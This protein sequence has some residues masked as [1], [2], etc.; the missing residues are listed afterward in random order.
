MKCSDA[1]FPVTSGRDENFNFIPFTTSK[2]PLAWGCHI[3]FAGLDFTFSVQ[4]AVFYICLFILYV[5]GMGLC[6]CTE[7]CLLRASVPNCSIH[8][9]LFLL[10]D[11]VL[12]AACK[13]GSPTSTEQETVQEAIQPVGEGGSLHLLFCT[14]GAVVCLLPQAWPV[15][16]RKARTKHSSSEMRGAAGWEVGIK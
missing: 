11:S 7:G 5:P 6:V 8:G 14:V 9:A 1:T 10:L 15:D 4:L 16:M 2:A 13:A 12:A 3:A